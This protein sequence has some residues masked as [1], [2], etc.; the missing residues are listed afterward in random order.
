MARGGDEDGGTYQ[1]LSS[2]SNDE[3][4][5]NPT[6]GSVYAQFKEGISDEEKILVRCLGSK[7]AE[8]SPMIAKVCDVVELLNIPSFTCHVV[9]TDFDD[10]LSYL[11][12]IFISISREDEQSKS[13]LYGVQKK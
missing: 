8:K 2:R 5:Q 9:F 3:E 4:M 11:N 7:S 12:D 13:L 6:Y 1:I 10:T